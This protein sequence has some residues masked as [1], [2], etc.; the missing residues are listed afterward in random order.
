MTRAKSNL[1]YGV[2]RK[3]P[4]ADRRVLRDEVIRLKHPSASAP[5]YLRRMVAVVE[6]NGQKRKMVFLTSNLEWSPW[7]VAELYR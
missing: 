6:I 4:N 7:T 2:Y 5:E 1:A 3:L